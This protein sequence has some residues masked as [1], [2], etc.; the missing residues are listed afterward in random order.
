[1]YA[2]CSLLTFSKISRVIFRSQIERKTFAHLSSS[3]SVTYPLSTETVHIDASLVALTSTHEEVF[4][5]NVDNAVGQLFASAEHRRLFAS[6][7]QKTPFIRSHVAKT[8]RISP[9]FRPQSPYPGHLPSH[10][11]GTPFFQSQEIDIYF[12]SRRK[13]PN[14]PGIRALRPNAA[15][16]S[17]RKSAKTQTVGGAARANFGIARGN[18]GSLWMS[19]RRHPLRNLTQRH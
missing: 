16:L 9:S 19:P 13:R 5:P 18:C 3:R 2:K 14:S 12:P 8:P 11:W 7:R 15:C 17:Q 6:A 1:M 10:T 4:A